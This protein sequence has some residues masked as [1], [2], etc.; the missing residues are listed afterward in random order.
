MT[1]VHSNRN[2]FLHETS[3]IFG[4]AKDNRKILVLKMKNAVGSI[5]KEHVAQARLKRNNKKN[6]S[7]QC[8][9]E[10]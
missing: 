4:F 10:L 1:L 9:Q 3:L 2:E 8:A 7:N 6:I 5:T